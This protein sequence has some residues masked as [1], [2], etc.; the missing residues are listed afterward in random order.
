MCNIAGCTGDQTKHLFTSTHHPRVVVLEYKG[1]VAVVG[2]EVADVTLI[3]VIAV[4]G[5]GN[6]SR[7]SRSCRKSS[8][9][10]R[11]Q[12]KL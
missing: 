6:S 4:K 2:V 10:G 8:K 9:H 11:K 12:E 7:N 3:Y 1:V 5:K